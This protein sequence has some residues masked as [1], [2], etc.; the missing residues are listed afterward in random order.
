MARMRASDGDHAPRENADRDFHVVIAQATRNGA[1]RAVVNRL[2]DARSH[3]LWTR[4][5]SHFH[6]PA[7]RARTLEDHAAIVAALEAHDPDAA[8]AAM[9]RHLGR[10]IREFQRQVEGP[11]AVPAP[12]S[13]KAAD[14]RAPRRA[15]E[16]GVT[17]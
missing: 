7:L 17:S 14:I 4:I 3:P 1:L 15:N 13:G 10:V 2:W 11:G 5:E 9:H 12:R 16:G 8:R 6:T